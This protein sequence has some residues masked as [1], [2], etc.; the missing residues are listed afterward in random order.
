MEDFRAHVY[1]L[2]TL[3]SI[4]A[5]VYS[6]LT[7]RSK[8]NAS[9]IKTIRENMARADTVSQ[10]QKK[11]GVHDERL[12]RIE[13]RLDHLADFI[14]EVRKEISQVHR[15]MDDL[16]G[17]VHKIEGTLSGVATGNR[18]VLEHLLKDKSE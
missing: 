9:E 11:D 18:L 2:A 12:T 10:M 1:I 6:W 3:I 4:A 5:M 14:P 7:A 13:T 17:A 8:V 16:T 15:R